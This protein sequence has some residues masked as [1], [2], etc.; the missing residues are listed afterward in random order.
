VP[1]RFSDAAC[2]SVGMAPK[3]GWT[4]NGPAA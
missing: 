1:W 3:N 2:L 4:A